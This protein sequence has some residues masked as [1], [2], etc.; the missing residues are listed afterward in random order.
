MA[1]G[2]ASR[3]SVS[4]MRDDMSTLRAEVV[5][6]RS[7]HE[8]TVRDLARLGAQNRALEAR[9]AELSAEQRATAANIAR[10]Q[11]RVDAVEATV[12]EAKLLASLPPTPTP[13][14]PAA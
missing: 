13:S 4:G 7:S 1:V 10:L 11:E 14:A 6:L 9:L 3:G 8:A 2:C 5:E 12:R